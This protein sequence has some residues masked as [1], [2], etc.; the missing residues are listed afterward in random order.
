MRCDDK[1]ADVGFARFRGDL[2]AGVNGIGHNQSFGIVGLT[3]LPDS[4][5]LLRAVEV[6]AFDIFGLDT[7]ALVGGLQ[8]EAQ[9]AAG[10]VAR[11]A[12]I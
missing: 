1:S 6:E 4:D 12:G 7:G 2:H 8:G 5:W 3:K 11:V 10:D 9:I